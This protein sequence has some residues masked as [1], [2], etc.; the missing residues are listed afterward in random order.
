MKRKTLLFSAS[1]L[2]VV[3]SLSASLISSHAQGRRQAPTVLSSHDG[4]LELIES[5]PNQ[6]ARAQAETTAAQLAE[7]TD[8]P[9]AAR[10]QELRQQLKTANTPEN[11]RCF[12]SFYQ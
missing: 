4:T 11:K 6:G 12:C 2:L 5:L 10:R 3:G 8:S 7:Q 1:A 9:E